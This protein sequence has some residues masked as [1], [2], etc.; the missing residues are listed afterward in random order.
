MTLLY[1][2]EWNKG[3]KQQ[4]LFAPPFCWF[5]SSLDALNKLNLTRGEVI[6]WLIWN[7]NFKQANKTEPTNE[8]VTSKKKYIY[9]IYKANLMQ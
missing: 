1:S 9:Y 5:S 3:K 6:L 8:S 7:F 2:A 4:L